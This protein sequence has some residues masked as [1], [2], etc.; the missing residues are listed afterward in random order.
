MWQVNMKLIS[1][2]FL[3]TFVS[4]GFNT[5]K[6]PLNFG[7][8]IDEPVRAEEVDFK[9]LQK[10]ILPKCLGCHQKWTTEE[11]FAKYI[12]P[13][14]PDE[15][16]FYDAVKTGRMPKRA[17]PLSSQ[18]L[19]IVRNYILNLK[20]V[21]PTPEPE[22]VP[23]PVPEPIPAPEPTPEPTPEPDPVPAPVA[24]TFKDLH[25]KVF[26]VS[27]LPCHA[28]IL[29]TEAALNSNWI[30]PENT[31]L[32]PL[33]VETESGRMPKRGAPLTAEQLQLIRD[34]VKQFR[35]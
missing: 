1:M 9:V 3:A 28:R 27:C 14:K 5:A 26:Q 11:A 12:V 31:D 25:E 19:E 17:Q 32:S 2:I 13:G 35:P 22:P 20:V 6:G 8:K 33:L 21:A 34:Y 24:V 16:Q 23:E 18:Q 4:C 30:D 10:Q 15:S 7:I 29:G